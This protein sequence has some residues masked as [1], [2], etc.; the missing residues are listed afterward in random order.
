MMQNNW[1]VDWAE[2][3]NG[4]I[5]VC[6]RKGIIVYM[7]RRSIEQFHKYGGA[8][9]LGSNLLDCHPEPSKTKL[10]EMLEKPVDNMYTTEKD[11]VTKIIYQTPWYQEGMFR[12]VIE[13]SFQLDTSMPHFFRK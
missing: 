4:A 2:E 8:D 7:N 5:T 3:F 11:G 12:G 6:D 9:L 13:I 1:N 10:K